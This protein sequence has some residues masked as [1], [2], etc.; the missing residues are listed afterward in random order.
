[1]STDK[2]I[3]AI[4]KATDTA[5][6][7]FQGRIPA[8]QRLIT[9]EIELLLKEL[10]ISNGILSNDITNLRI[11][12]Q[13]QSKV[14]SI[15]L[16]DKY[17]DS[18]KDFISSFSTIA[19]MQQAYISKISSENPNFAYLE[20]L[21]SMSIVSVVKSLTEDGLRANISN[22][23]SDILRQ[24]ITT[25]ASYHEL[26]TQLSDF[27]STNESGIG[28]L[29]RYTTQITTDAINQF[30]GQYLK[31]ATDNLFLRWSMYVG[32]NLT[33]TRE[34]CRHLTKKK[35]VYQPELQGILNGVIDGEE[36]EINDSTELPNGMIPGTN[37]SNFQ[38][39]RGGYNC[40]HQY[41]P[42]ADEFVP[43]NIRNTAYS[44]YGK[45]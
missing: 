20:Q 34:F 27:I 11:I 40:G 16:N 35:Y 26:R 19:D 12:G 37:T 33:T 30:N 6:E 28:A 36:V 5:I 3:Q 45:L 32:S 23:I 2:E 4:I 29:Q 41:V 38:V 17:S 10:K 8:I 24:N 21:K 18:V 13:I 22:K 9:N 14:N 39:Y 7:K 1:M 25:G 44:K 15:I 43:I 42:V 31:S